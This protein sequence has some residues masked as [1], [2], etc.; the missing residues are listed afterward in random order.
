ME[1]R[2]QVPGYVLGGEVSRDE[3]GIVLA[4]VSLGR[5][6]AVRVHVIE[7]PPPSDLVL[8]QL[9]RLTELT[10][11]GVLSPLEVL[12]AT[13]ADDKSRSVAVVSRDLEA[14]PLIELVADQD[15]TAGEVVGTFAPIADALARLHAAGDPEA[16]AG[17]HDA[18][19]RARL[20]GR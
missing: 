9:A 5:G 13:R 8:A 12:S 1:Q 2:W 7:G 10:L 15:L 20:L 4:G 11:D 3:F 6:A 14:T 18:P 17:A 19:R 16:R